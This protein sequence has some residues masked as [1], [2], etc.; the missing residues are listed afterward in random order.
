M[1]V[2]EVLMVL[3]GILS[4]IILYKIYKGSLIE[5]IKTYCNPTIKNPPELCPS[6][7]ECPQ[8]G[9][10]SCLCPTPTPPTPPAPTVTE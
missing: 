1:K 6:G 7:I 4:L 5:G 2:K 9:D 3:I 10:N 8:C